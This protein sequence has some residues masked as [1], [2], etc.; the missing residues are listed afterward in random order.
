L[1]G[2]IVSTTIGEED[3]VC[4][5]NKEGVAILS[6]TPGSALI[7]KTVLSVGRFGE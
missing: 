1:K 7:E 5:V 2:E 6:K 3:L 4:I